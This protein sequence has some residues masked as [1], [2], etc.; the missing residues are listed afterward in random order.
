VRLTSAAAS[1]RGPSHVAEGTPCEDA[2]TALAD[3][4]GSLFVVADGVGSC[5]SARLGAAT[6]VRAARAAWRHWAPS[7]AGTVD[8]LVR[9]VEVL[10]RLGLGDVAP[11]DAATTCLVCA[12]RADGSGVIAQLGDGFVGVLRGDALDALEVD[13][14][15]FA[16]QTHSLGG[17]H[18][19]RDWQRRPIEALAPGDVLMLATDGVADDLVPERRAAFVRWAHDEARRAKRPA[20]RIA[21]M[22]TA[23]PVPRHLDDK[24]LLLAWRE[25]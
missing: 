24:T 1:V 5:P 14:A 12:L 2:W 16:S 23:W 22:L 18:G 13:R 20:R 15:G 8:D 7:S 6:A 17:P 11:S 9:L 4:R 3:H 21:A 19:L 25:A 10:W